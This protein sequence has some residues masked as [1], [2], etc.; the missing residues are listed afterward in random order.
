MKKATKRT[1]ATLL[2]C[3]LLCG[4]LAVGASAMDYTVNQEAKE[5]NVYQL[6]FHDYL[7]YSVITEY[8]GEGWQLVSYDGDYFYYTWGGNGFIALKRGDSTLTVQ[9][10]EE[11]TWTINAHIDYSFAQWLCVIFLAGWA[12]MKDTPPGRFD[13][14]ESIWYI[15]TFVL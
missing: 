5:I 14:I 6:D 4:G 8:V 7:F 10:A 3:L 11:D 9:S 15:V 13:L 1:L 2:A 12:W